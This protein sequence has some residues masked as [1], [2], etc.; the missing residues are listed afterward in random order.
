MDLRGE[1]SRAVDRSSGRRDTSVEFSWN[2]NRNPLQ[3][4]VLR[5]LLEPSLMNPNDWNALIQFNYPG[6]FLK[7]NLA[8]L[9]QR[10]SS[11][12]SFIPARY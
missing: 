5:T 4:M 7:C 1:F 6:T 11:I 10:N 2:A 9:T 8:A 12:V 3:K